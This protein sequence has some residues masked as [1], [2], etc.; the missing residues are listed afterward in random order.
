MR[1]N[2]NIILPSLFLKVKS[3]K[4]ESSNS[5]VKREDEED[6]EEKDEEGCKLG[7]KES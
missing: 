1:L 5:N 2:I 4:P 6:K 3:V 7:C